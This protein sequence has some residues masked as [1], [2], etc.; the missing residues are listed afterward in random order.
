MRSRRSLESHPLQTRACNQKASRRHPE[1]VGLERLTHKEAS[2]NQREVLCLEPRQDLSC[3]RRKADTARPYAQATCNAS[4]CS[5]FSDSRAR[6]RVLRIDLFKSRQV[7]RF[8]YIIVQ[9]LGAGTFLGQEVLHR[10]IIHWK[11]CRSPIRA[12]GSPLQVR[13]CASRMLQPVTS[14]SDIRQ[15]SPE[16]TEWAPLASGAGATSAALRGSTKQALCSEIITAIGGILTAS[17]SGRAVGSHESWELVHAPADLRGQSVI[18]RLRHGSRTGRHA[19]RPRRP[20]R[21]G[22]NHGRRGRSCPKS[23]SCG[24]RRGQTRAIAKG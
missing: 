10:P 4:C 1:R 12:A 22:N 23:A 6:H 20:R 18:M 11:R 3:E 17:Q 9:H 13:R 16:H 7:P 24:G 14:A 21:R 2:A 15:P 8:A 5:V 19:A